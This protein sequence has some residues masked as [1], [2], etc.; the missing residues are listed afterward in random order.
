[1][2]RQICVTLDEQTVRKICDKIYRS[3][4]KSKSQFIEKSVEAYLE[5]LENE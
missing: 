4:F 5:I 3:S 1:M 2:K